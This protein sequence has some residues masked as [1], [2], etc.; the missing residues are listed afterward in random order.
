[1]LKCIHQEI[2]FPAVSSLHNSIYTLLPYKDMKG[3]WKVTVRVPIL[4]LSAGLL[5][6]PSELF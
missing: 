6:S 5:V 1:M 4:V 2:I 3:E